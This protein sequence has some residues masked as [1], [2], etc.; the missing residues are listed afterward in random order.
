M[1]PP[2]Q[3][4]PN[5]IR[6]IILQTRAQL[7]VPLKLPLT[8]P[9][10]N[11]ASQEFQKRQQ[12]IG[13]D[14]TK[15]DPIE[16]L[17]EA[18]RRLI[19]K[20][21]ARDPNTDPVKIAEAKRWHGTNPVEA[22]GMPAQATASAALY[23]LERA[24]P[25]WE[26]PIERGIQRQ[27]MLSPS[28]GIGLRGVMEQAG[29]ARYPRFVRGAT[30]AVLDPYNLVAMPFI[31]KPVR[32]GLGLALR[33]A[34][35]LPGFLQRGGRSIPKARG[36][37]DP[38]VGGGSDYYPQSAPSRRPEKGAEYEAWEAEGG[39]D[40]E[41]A[42]KMV[43][44]GEEM[45]YSGPYPEQRDWSTGTL[46]H[47]APSAKA[48]NY[49]KDLRRSTKAKKEL[50]AYVKQ[51]MEMG[52]KEWYNTEPIRNL[53]VGR[54]G[55]D[56]GHRL[57][58][59]FINLVG[60]A[61][62]GSDV[63]GNIRVGSLLRKTLKPFEG[64]MGRSP[65]E[66]I[67]AG[68]NEQEFNK[69]LNFIDL[70]SKGK[71]IDVPDG[72]GR[73]YGIKG[74]FKTI[75]SWAEGK[76]DDPN[77]VNSPKVRSF[78]AALLGSKEAVAIDVHAMRIMG[79]VSDSPADWLGGKQA[80]GKDAFE[81]LK[82]KYSGRRV[83]RLINKDGKLVK[84]KR[85]KNGKLDLKD[86]DQR[87]KLSIHHFLTETEKSWTGKT[88]PQEAI[89]YKFNASEAVKSGLVDIE[90]IKHMPSV[91]RKAPAKNDYGELA[92]LMTELAAEEGI[93][94]AQA[95]ASIWLAAAERTGVSG[96][97]RGTFVDLVINRIFAQAEDQNL[98]PIAIIH[99][100][101]QNRGLIS[102]LAGLAGLQGMRSIQEEEDEE[103][104]EPVAIEAAQ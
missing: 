37:L 42:G 84:R 16:K 55:D 90:D 94:P 7:G 97:S 89:N 76:W 28:G 104:E 70:V 81:G 21:L 91:Y 87:K 92:Q 79:M 50:T 100:L 96:L 40:V 99:D 19:R 24:I 93:T 18:H 4:L 46:A 44:R 3:Q 95:Q 41:E 61:S 58:V 52:G 30:E 2:N 29:T 102:F 63:Q 12:A 9:E 86:G 39:L 101:I 10:I 22:L 85:L 27:R 88:G 72:Y 103:E 1:P 38:F 57:F 59:Q 35:A 23:G 33:G 77:Y 64:S 17:R 69:M 78:A 82:A 5:H 60:A 54:F 51:G 6:K 80:I 49:V 14:S 25:F 68:V 36:G 48:S 15:T 8:Q 83:E 73:V 45:A 65:G 75:K 11:A 53:F 71:G 66:A 56:E 47:Q 34:R 62:P 31:E 20:Q 26:G 98:P 32:A 13:L 74:L 67:A 43:A